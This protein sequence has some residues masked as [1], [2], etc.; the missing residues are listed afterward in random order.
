MPLSENIILWRNLERIKDQLLLDDSEFAQFLDIPY[1]EYLRNKNKQ[2]FLP[3]TCMFEFS[4]KLNLHFEDLLSSEFK[5]NSTIT[6]N[7]RDM[8]LADRYSIASY[9]KTKPILNI[10]N[11][12][13]IH[14]GVRAKINLLRKFQL[15]EEFILNQENNTNIF[16]IS[17]IAKYLT[18]LYN[19]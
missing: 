3:L 19:S 9:S 11:Y 16:L 5:L 15:T 13:E 6:N 2:L 7:N 8:I 18:N 14:R 4:E 1:Q 12:L 17:D 10:I